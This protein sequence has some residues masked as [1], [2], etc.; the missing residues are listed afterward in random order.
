MNLTDVEC[1]RT[2]NIQFL[3]KAFG[4]DRIQVRAKFPKCSPC[5]RLYLVKTR[6]IYNLLHTKPKYLGFNHRQPLVFTSIILAGMLERYTHGILLAFLEIRF[7]SHPAITENFHNC[8]S[9][10]NFP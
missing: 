1:V 4:I 10:D 2:E 7:W 3:A 8:L 5:T 9:N 6:A